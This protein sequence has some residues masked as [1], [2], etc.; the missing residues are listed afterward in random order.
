[1]NQVALFLLGGM[2]LSAKKVKMVSWRVITV[3]D[4]P[5]NQTRHSDSIVCLWPLWLLLTIAVAVVCSVASVGLRHHPSCFCE[6]WQ[7]WPSVDS[8]SGNRL[9]WREP[10]CPLQ[11]QFASRD[12]PMPTFLKVEQLCR[13]ILAPELSL[14]QL[15]LLLHFS[16]SICLIY[17]CHSCMTADPKKL[18]NKLPKHKSS[19]Q[20]TSW[21]TWPQNTGHLQNCVPRPGSNK[22]LE[23]QTFDQGLIAGM[24]MHI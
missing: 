15:R 10:I 11:T 5:E 19:S 13:V 4:S 22:Q 16:S 17:A 18:L 21:G 3:I 1:M 12:I 20:S 9:S 6:C 24:K 2:R 8:I 7:R 14:D 23:T